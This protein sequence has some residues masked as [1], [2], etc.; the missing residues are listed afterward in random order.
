MKLRMKGNSIRLRLTKSE[1]GQLLEGQPVTETVWFTPETSLLYSLCL[2]E[3]AKEIGAEFAAG[4][5]SVVVPVALGT[6]WANTDLVALKIEQKN[7]QAEA[8]QILI[9]KDFFCLKPRSHQ[10]E[11]ES[12]MFQNPNE[13]HGACQ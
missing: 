5:I 11:D 10:A 4:K 9:E 6:E 3:K 8:L 2:D 13:A 7:A 1:V 12:D